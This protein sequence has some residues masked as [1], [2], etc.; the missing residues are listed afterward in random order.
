MNRKRQDE[1]LRKRFNR[2]V[3]LI[4]AVVL[5]LSSVQMSSPV[6]AF[7]DQNSAVVSETETLDKSVDEAQKTE[8]GDTNPVSDA[9]SQNEIQTETQSSSQG[10]VEEQAE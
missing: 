4:C 3:S 7:A 6:T 10:P 2:I 8:Q 9:S 1:N 5:L